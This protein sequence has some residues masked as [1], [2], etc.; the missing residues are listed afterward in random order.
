[1]IEQEIYVCIEGLNN[2]R[3]GEHQPKPKWMDKT[4]AKALKGQA[5][6][7]YYNQLCSLGEKDIA[8][9]LLKLKK[10]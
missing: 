7:D 3:W 4:T 5:T 2:Q 10:I 8:I 1:M 9:E 6:W